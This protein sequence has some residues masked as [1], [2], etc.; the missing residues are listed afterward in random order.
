MTENRGR[1]KKHAIILMENLAMLA[2]NMII[3]SKLG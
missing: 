2:L 3:M 1:R